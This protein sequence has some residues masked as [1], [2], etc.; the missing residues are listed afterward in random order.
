MVV[1]VVV[2]VVGVES[3]CCRRV[4]SPVLFVRALV[5]VRESTVVVLESLR[6]WRR[7]LVYNDNFV[8]AG[9]NYV[10]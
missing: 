10:L 8:W 6:K 3:C 7:A 2:V 9:H 5:G 4:W 1:V